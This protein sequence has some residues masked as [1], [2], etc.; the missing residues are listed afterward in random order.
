M[1]EVVTRPAANGTDHQTVCGT[2]D[3]PTARV[4]ITCGEAKP[5]NEFAKDR[6]RRHGRRGDV[7]GVQD[8]LRP[9]AGLHQACRMYGHR[10]VVESFTT[11]QL[12]ERHGDRC[13]YCGSR[14]LRVHRPPHV[15]ASRWPPHPRQHGAVLPE[16]NQRKRWAVDEVLI[17]VYRL[18]FEVARMTGGLWSGPGPDHRP[19][20]ALPR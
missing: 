7:R 5:L 20:R 19:N 12:I 11:Q 9:R 6:R 18:R 17:R 3:E 15:R 2:D 16:C 10:P 8:E 1:S 14:R 4:C 13:F